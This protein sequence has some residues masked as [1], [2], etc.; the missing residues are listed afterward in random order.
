MLDSGYDAASA[1]RAASLV[2]KEG[3]KTDTEAQT[4]ED[5]I[6][7]VFLKHYAVGFASGHADDKVVSIIAKTW[8]KMSPDGHN[9]ALALEL[10]PGLAA[11]VGEALQGAE[12]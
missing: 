1:A 9:A 12:L 11:L 5:V 6:C 7:L 10:P 2:R 8:R 3:L 4:L